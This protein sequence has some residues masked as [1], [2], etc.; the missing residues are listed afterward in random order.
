MENGPDSPYQ[1]WS[2]W[3]KT[4]LRIVGLSM[5]SPTPDNGYGKLHFTSHIYLDDAHVYR[6]PL[7]TL[8][9]AVYHPH[10]RSFPHS[11]LFFCWIA[12][13]YYCYFSP[14]FLLL[15]ELFWNSHSYS[16]PLQAVLFHLFPEHLLLSKPSH[17]LWFSNIPFCSKVLI[18]NMLLSDETFF[19]RLLL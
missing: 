16:H 14:T 10:T 3:R 1:T 9:S 19:S 12:I 7:L 11:W 18:S 6:F 4:E 17:A 2:T 8:P 15:N 13:N 5:L